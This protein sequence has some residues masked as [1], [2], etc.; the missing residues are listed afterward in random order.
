MRRKFGL[1][2]ACGLLLPLVVTASAS[3]QGATLRISDTTPSPGD[4]VT[5]T[6]T[7][8]SNASPVSI[9]FDSRYGAERASG[10]ATSAGVLQP[11]PLPL[12]IPANL[13]PGWHLIF[14]T[15]T[16]EATGRARGFTP[17]RVRI[18]VGAPSSGGSAAP[19]PGGGRGG[20]P[21]SP[22]GLLAVGSALILLATGATL[23]ARKLRAQ[24]RPQLGR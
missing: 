7:G 21:G 6:G 8:F 2:L 24:N 15:Q 16:V 19:A 20:L 5:L 9:R 18:N 17:G 14:A 12:T 4:Q 10:T 3:G 23:T 1:F 22:L 13:S 11:N